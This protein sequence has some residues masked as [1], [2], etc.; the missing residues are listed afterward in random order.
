MAK[1]NTTGLPKKK[2]KVEE[3]S[4]EENL[5]LIGQ[6]SKNARDEEKLQRMIMIAVGGVIGILLVLIVVGVL[7]SQLIV[8]NQTVA[9]VDGKNISVSEF[10]ERVRLERVTLNQRLNNDIAL[11][12]SFGQDPNAI[13]QQEPY[14]TWW[15]ELN[16]QPELLGSRVLNDMIDEQI[17]RAEAEARGITPDEETVQEEVEQFFNFFRPLEDATEEA[18]EDATETSD[19][20]ETPTP[21]VSPTPSSTPPPTDIP[22]PTATPTPLVEE[23][24]TEDA[25][26]EPTARPT[27]T[28]SPTASFEDRE[29]EFE[30]TV[31]IFYQNARSE[32]DLSE[33]TVRQYFE[34]EAML[35]K[36]QEVV[37]ADVSR[38][39]PYVNVRHIL[40]E[41]EEAAQDVMAALDAGESFAD[42]ARAVSIDTGSGSR[43]GELGWSPA[44]QF[45]PEFRDATLEL[46]IG[47]IS[48]PV[49]SDFG[50]HIIQVRAREDREM[51]DSEYDQ[52][53]TRFF[54]EWLDEITN[55][56]AHQIERRDNWPAHVPTEPRFVY[57]PPGIELEEDTTSNQ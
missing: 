57:R 53:K 6:F 29:A 7:W 40:V 41:T 18:V 35:S 38:T 9:V 33:A 24:A 45:V 48:D 10:T 14:G 36:L 42:L 25:G 44:S 49:Q 12:I 4:A 16:F 37:T 19:P 8:P 54:Q 32:A 28:P 21:F 1:R 13:L 11:L 31:N 30:N 34:Y 26:L 47:V 46:E 23:I 52:A 17:I 43:G 55:E 2:K 56:E 3:A 27:S 39:A 20:S 50:Y 22:A 15:Q 51:T 5:D